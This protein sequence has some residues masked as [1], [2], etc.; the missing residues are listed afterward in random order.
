MTRISMARAR[1]TS[2]RAALLAGAA[3]LSAA[4]TQ[5]SA[6]AVEE[7]VVTAQRR[8]EKLQDVP[9]AISAFTGGQ[10]ERLGIDSSRELTQIT[11]GLNFTQ[12][13]YSPQ[14][15][16][17][18]IG[19]RGVGAGD[20]SQVP[21]YI[22]GVYQA[23]LQGAILQFNNV[24]RIEVLK[25]PQGALFGRNAT[26]GAINIITKKP[27]AGFTGD[28]S[29]SYGRFSEWAVKGYVAAGSDT[30]GMDLAVVADGSD[31]YIKDD[32]RKDKYGDYENFTARSKILF[33]PNDEVE[34]TVAGSWTNN[35][36]SL[37][38]AYNSFG[39]NTNGKR[40]A[41]NLVTSQNYRSHLNFHPYYKVNQANVSLTAV[42]KFTGFDVTA[43]T[44]YQN[45]VMK[46]K[47]DSDATPFELNT[48]ISRQYSRNT[49]NEIYATSNG[50][51]AFS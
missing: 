14:P 39:G 29:A 35:V 46:N 24:E 33:R 47:T 37:G 4:A 9:A 1:Q 20:E 40:L 32:L 11:P 5:A 42:L 36:D 12:S 3:I 22:D 21:I 50:E 10:L 19:V 49:Y 41:G 48:T 2:T 43:L 15:T 7:V 6:Q 16:I 51:G 30:M 25:G 28:L 34:L 27:K 38:V 26:G 18:G 45:S 13:V 17:R 31:G 44:G 23:F 8:E